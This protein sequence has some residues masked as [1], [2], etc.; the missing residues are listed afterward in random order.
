MVRERRLRYRRRSLMAWRAM[1]S[2]SGEHRLVLGD[3]LQV[4]VGLLDDL[5]DDRLDDVAGPGDLL[6]DE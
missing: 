2:T 5:L 6:V 1:L 3:G 4:F